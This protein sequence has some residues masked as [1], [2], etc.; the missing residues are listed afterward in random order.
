MACASWAHAISDTYSTKH[1]RTSF[2]DRISST[3]PN[4]F[5]RAPWATYYTILVIGLHISQKYNIGN[6]NCQMKFW[7]T[8]AINLK[9]VVI[10]S[11]HST[12]GRRHYLYHT[13]NQEFTLTDVRSTRKETEVTTTDMTKRWKTSNCN[14]GRIL[15]KAEPLQ[16]KFKRLR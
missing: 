4:I 1:I 3:F 9:K 12:Q 14:M 6:Q 16:T 5:L 10:E 8:L 15:Y 13:R 7:R 11:S 2:F